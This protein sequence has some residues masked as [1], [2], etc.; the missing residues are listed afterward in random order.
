MYVHTYVW[1][2]STRYIISW[3]TDTRVHT[4]AY[5][6]MYVCMYTLAEPYFS[7]CYCTIWYS[8]RQNKM[9]DWRSGYARSNTTYVHSAYVKLYILY[10]HII[11]QGSLLCV[12]YWFYELGTSVTLKR[13]KTLWFIHM[14]IFSSYR[15][16]HT[17]Y[18]VPT[19]GIYYVYCTYCTYCT[20][21]KYCTQ[22]YCIHFMYLLSCFRW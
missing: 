11:C 17:A 10:L 13:I 5:I 7:F 15:C 19:D 2:S 16:I 18:A 21:C 3:C 12:S 22:K 14:V 9:V 8:A 1:V 4:T 6:C 20:Y